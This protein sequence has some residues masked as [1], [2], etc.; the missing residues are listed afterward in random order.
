MAAVID[1]TDSMKYSEEDLNF[2]YSDTFFGANDENTKNLLDAY[3]S[4]NDVEH[5]LK[6]EDIK[7]PLFPT[8]V[9][10]PKDNLNY[11]YDIDGLVIQLNNLTAVK[12]RIH[13]LFVGKVMAPQLQQHWPVLRKHLPLAEYDATGISSLKKTFGHT[14]AFMDGGYALNLSCMTALTTNPHPVFRSEMAARANASQMINN[15][16]HLFATK[17]KS[18]PAQDLQRPTIMKNNLN[19]LKR[20]HILE[21]DQS[22]VLEI[23]SQ[24]IQQINTDP[25][26]KLVMF[27][28]KFGQKEESALPI[29]ALVNRR[30]VHSITCHSACTIT[31]KDPRVD[32]MWSR[33]GLQKVVGHRGNIFTTYAMTEAANFQTNIDQHR[34]TLDRDL[35]DVFCAAIYCS[36]ITFVQLYATTP[37]VRGDMFKHPVSRV[38]AT[39]GMHIQKHNTSILQKAKSY[40]DHMDDL[41]KKT[42]CRTQAR[43]EAVFLLDNNI[44]HVLEARDFYNPQAIYRLLDSNPMLLT[45]KDNAHGL[46]LRHVTQPVAAYLTNTL[47]TLLEECKGRGGYTSSWMA[48]QYEL[49]LEEMLFGKPYS[50]S[51]N[52]FS[53]SLGT[54]TTNQNSLS[55]HRGFLGLSPVGSASVGEDPPP[56]ETW[57]TDPVQQMRIRRI[58][59]FTE[60]LNATPAV[61]GTALVQVLLCD[62]HE[63]NAKIS[64][65]TFKHATV[66]FMCKL[67]GCRTTSE[68]CKDLVER[69]AFTYPHTFGRAVQLAQ[70]AG[71]NVLECL[72]LGLADFKIFPAIVYWDEKRHPKAK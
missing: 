17:L 52:Q 69:K 47:Y 67:V 23:L 54:N 57:I 55:R 4:H 63:R 71:H 14:L 6:D 40:I 12:A 45:F 60:T 16:L 64:T 3:Y 38:I 28:T 30:Q 43:I 59:P 70:E 13:Y 36:D 68:L 53:V 9:Q 21:H 5:F 51:S 58:F 34:I 48:F 26:Q 1:L 41:T 29:A 35:L 32:L 10:N 62:L 19:D 66:P 56:I 39:C 27:M 8:T 49:A 22:F 7:I 46:G 37:H 24:A 61:I 20:M 65:D 42:A 11:T 31:P 72:Q 44:P 25:T 33:Y 50:H 18:L 15:V 2:L